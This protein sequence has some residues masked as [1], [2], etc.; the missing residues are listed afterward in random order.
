MRGSYY[1][2]DKSVG[3]NIGQAGTAVKANVDTT[4]GPPCQFCTYPEENRLTYIGPLTRTVTVWASV[5]ITS[6]NNKVIEVAIRKN[7]QDVEWL[8]SLIRTGNTGGGN[9]AIV[10]HVELATND[11]LEVWL[12]NRTSTTSVTVVDLTLAARG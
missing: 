4:A 3:T 2:L 11:Y 1:A 12:T 10:G 8:K 9:A 7:G 5:A 6:G